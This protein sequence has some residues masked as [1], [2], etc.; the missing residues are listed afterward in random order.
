MRQVNP[1]A[2]TDKARG[3]DFT[4]LSSLKQGQVFREVGVIRFK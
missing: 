3:Q 2:V 1:F 4:C